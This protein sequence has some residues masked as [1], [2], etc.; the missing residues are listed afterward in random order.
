MV[1]YRVFTAQD[2]IEADTPQEAYEKWCRLPLVTVI[3][4]EDAPETNLGFKVSEF[5]HINRED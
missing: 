4:E 5:L 1:K 2:D 3:I